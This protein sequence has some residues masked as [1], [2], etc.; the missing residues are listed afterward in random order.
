MFLTIRDTSGSILMFF[1]F[2]HCA[3]YCSMHVW[4]DE[5]EKEGKYVR[6]GCVVV[7]APYFFPHTYL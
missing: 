3:N 6:G 1:S 7:E 4:Q 5:W 2:C